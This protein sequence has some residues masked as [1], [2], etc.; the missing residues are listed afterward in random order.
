MPFDVVR[1]V[2]AFLGTLVVKEKTTCFHVLTPSN[3]VS[4]VAPLMSQDETYDV[5]FGRRSADRLTVV[6]YIDTPHPLI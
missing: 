2:S 6:V 3:A 5:G 4:I 1:F